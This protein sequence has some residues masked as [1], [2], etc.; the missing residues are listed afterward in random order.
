MKKKIKI[1]GS[2]PTGSLLALFLAS[3]DCNIDIV[4]PLSDIELLSRDKGYAITQSSR[5]IFE[6]LGIWSSLEKVSFGFNSLSIID[7]ETS[8][9]VIVRTNDLRKF[10]KNQSNIGWVIEHKHFMKILL[11]QINSNIYINKSTSD[12][13]DDENFDFILAAD[14]RESGTRKAWKTIYHKR[15][16]K[17]RCISFK[18]ILKGLPTKRAYEIF[19]D[20]GPLAL[21]PA[22]NDIYQVIWFSS[23]PKVKVQLKQDNS[24]L[25]SELMNILPDN[26]YAKEI[27]SEVSNYSLAKA[28]ALP[29]F[30]GFNKIL[31]G[32][33]A[34]SFHPVGGQGLNS[35]IRDV[36]ELSNLINNYESIS[37]VKKKFFSI[38]YYFKR[39]GDIFSLLIV[40]DFLI[41]LFCNR[42]F[43]LYPL[44]SFIFFLLRSYKFIR[45]GVFSLMTDSLKGNLFLKNN[46]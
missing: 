31:V 36:Y 44:R 20:Q 28:F 38:Y 8:Q 42:L 13:K 37:V 16:Y 14:G 21:L 15:F 33:S 43:F 7:N 45:C 35:C 12:L 18:A 29:N 39:F 32:D 2:G 22:G 41:K 19:K 6:K 17:Q 10:N 5:R 26:I 46:F 11:D 3:E 23:I 1:L 30:A 24:Q 4:E 34:H 40:T 9:S 25:L 27:V